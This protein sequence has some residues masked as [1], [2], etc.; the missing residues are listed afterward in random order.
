MVGDDGVFD[1]FADPAQD[2]LKK[3][4]SKRRN[5]EKGR[6]RTYGR[7]MRRSV[8]QA[9]LNKP[10]D[11]LPNLLRTIPQRPSMLG[12]DVLK[13]AHEEDSEHVAHFLFR[14]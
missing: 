8:R 11:D 13:D 9:L 12:R 14:E 6:E 2:A 1:C 3:Y 4:C 5:R 10:I 7:S